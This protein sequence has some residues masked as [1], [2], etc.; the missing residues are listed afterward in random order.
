MLGYTWRNYICVMYSF[1]FTF[2]VIY[3]CLVNPTFPKSLHAHTFSFTNTHTHTHTHTHLQHLKRLCMNITKI[4][5][6]FGWLFWYHLQIQIWGNRKYP[7]M[8]GLPS[9]QSCMEMTD[10]CTY[11][12]L[13][14]CL[15]KLSKDSHL[16]QYLRSLMS[17]EN[18]Y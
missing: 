10:T 2:M 8:P 14:Y 17:P 18:S 11:Y 1:W 6:L 12:S 5:Q 9:L 4:Y 16:V 7:A 3:V 13:L 15:H